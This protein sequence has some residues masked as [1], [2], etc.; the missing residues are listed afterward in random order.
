MFTL[1]IQINSAWRTLQAILRYY[2]IRVH[3]CT[4]A[5]FQPVYSNEFQHLYG[6]PFADVALDVLDLRVLI[7]VNEYSVRER[8]P[9][10][11]P[12][13]IHEAGHLFTGMSNTYEIDES[14][15]LYWEYTIAKACGVKDAWINALSSYAITHEQIPEYAK[16]LTP[17]EVK[18]IEKQFQPRQAHVAFVNIDKK[19]HDLILKHARIVAENNGWLTQLNEIITRVKEKEKV[20][21]RLEVYSLNHSQRGMM[22]KSST[23]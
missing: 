18:H 15:F 13:V 6:C 2:N 20:W 14:S 8:L 3:W 10:L 9:H 19:T 1:G 12:I 11:L 23:N 22:K 21:K 17:E 4:E 7:P 5:E 16:V